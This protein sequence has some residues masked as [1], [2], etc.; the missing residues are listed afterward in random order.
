MMPRNFG[1]CCILFC[2]SFLPSHLMS[3]HFLEPLLLQQPT[4]SL[5]APLPSSQHTR[6]HVFLGTSPPLLG[7][8]SWGVW[9]SAGCYN[10]V[11]LHNKNVLLCKTNKVEVQNQG[12][13]R[14]TSSETVRENLVQAS[15]LASG[16]W[17][18]I[19]WSLVSGN[20]TPALFLFSCGGLLVYRTVY[21]F[22]LL[23]R[24]QVLLD[25][26]LLLTVSFNL[27]TSAM[28]LFQIR[29]PGG[30]WTSK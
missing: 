11:L 30:G 23:I 13:G 21:R 10:R 25:S 8:D 29:S 18:R 19:W 20:I 3:L 9:V 26:R 12:D 2:L 7:C 1:F 15:C 16:G 24:P 17:W 22:S 14:V 28:R 6:S 5:C 27:I 4:P